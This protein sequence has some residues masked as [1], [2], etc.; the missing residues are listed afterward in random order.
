M[1]GRSVGDESESRLQF[2][3]DKTTRSDK[4]ECDL[5]EQSEA[6]LSTGQRV[7]RRKLIKILTAL[8]KCKKSDEELENYLVALGKD[9][10]EGQP[11]RFDVTESQMTSSQA[12]H[13]G[14]GTSPGSQPVK[15]R[16]RQIPGRS[17]SSGSEENKDEE[18]EEDSPDNPLS[19]RERQGTIPD[20][21]QEV[22]F[23]NSLQNSFVDLNSNVGRRRKDPSQLST[24]S[25]ENLL[26]GKV[27]ETASIKADSAT[28]QDKYLMKHIN[29]VSSHTNLP[30]HVASKSAANLLKPSRT[31]FPTLKPIQDV[32]QIEEKRLL[33]ERTSLKFNKLFDA[34]LKANIR[35]SFNKIKNFSVA[36]SPVVRSLIGRQ[37]SDDS[38]GEMADYNRLLGMPSKALGSSVGGNSWVFK[39]ASGDFE[40]SFSAPKKMEENISISPIRIPSPDG[41]KKKLQLLPV[42]GLIRESTEEDIDH[43][44]SH[45]SRSPASFTLLVFIAHKIIHRHNKEL[46]RKALYCMNG[47]YEPELYSRTSSN[48]SSPRLM[49]APSLLKVPSVSKLSK[50]SVS[51]DMSVSQFA[52]NYQFEKSALLGF[53]RLILSIFERQKIAGFIN[54][55]HNAISVLRNQE[56]L[57][58]MVLIIEKIAFNK[59]RGNFWQ[60]ISSVQGNAYVESK[61]K[62]KARK[63]LISLDKLHLSFPP[64]DIFE[65]I[66]KKAYEDKLNSQRWQR[67]CT[68]AKYI[69]RV[70]STLQ[71]NQMQRA[72][73]AIR[74]ID[75]LKAVLKLGQNQ[76]L[77]KIL[78]QA[79]KDVTKYLA[80]KAK[81]AKIEMMNFKKKG[82]LNNM[83]NNM[84][85]LQLQAIEKLRSITLDKGS[86]K[87]SSNSLKKRLIVVIE[88]HQTTR[89]RT[90]FM[91]LILNNQRFKIDNPTPQISPKNYDVPQIIFTPRTASREQVMKNI[92]LLRIFNSLKEKKIRCFQRIRDMSRIGQ[93][94]SVTNLLKA[95]VTLRLLINVKYGLIATAFHSIYHT[96]NKKHEENEEIMKLRTTACN[97]FIFNLKKKQI[98]ALSKLCIFNTSRK[99]EE[100]NNKMENEKKKSIIVKLVG[101]LESKMHHCFTGLVI[102][103]T[104]VECLDL[105]EKKKESKKAGRR[106][107]WSSAR[108]GDM[109]DMETGELVDPLTGVRLNLRTGERY[110]PRTGKRTLLQKEDMFDAARGEIVDVETGIRYN[111]QTGERHDLETGKKTVWRVGSVLDMKTGE[112]LARREQRE[113]KGGQQSQQPQHQQQS[114]SGSVGG[115]VVGEREES[116]SQQYHTERVD[117]EPDRVS[118]SS[119]ELHKSS[120]SH[121]LSANEPDTSPKKSF[122]TRQGDMIDMETGEL[123]DPLTGVRLNLRTG[124]R[125]DPR[126]GK[127]TLLQKE[128]MFDAA[129]GEIVDVETGI[130][131]NPQTGERHDLETGKKT[132]WRV[133]SVLDMKTGELLAR[134]EQREQKGGQQ[135]QQPQQHGVDSEH[136]I[137]DRAR[138]GSFDLQSSNKKPTTNQPH[139]E[140]NLSQSIII[141][142]SSHHLL[143]ELPPSIALGSLKLFSSRDK[144]TSE[145]RQK[146]GKSASKLESN[147]NSI[148]NVESK[149]ENTQAKPEKQNLLSLIESV[150]SEEYSNLKSNNNLPQVVDKPSPTLPIDDSKDQNIQKTSRGGIEDISLVDSI[151]DEIIQ[152][153]TGLN[154]NVEDFIAQK[155][156]LQKIEQKNQPEESCETPKFNQGE[157]PIPTPLKQVP[158]EIPTK[159]SVPIALNPDVKLDSVNEQYDNINILDEV[160]KSIKLK[161]QTADENK[162]LQNRKGNSINEVSKVID[163]EKKNMHPDAKGQNKD[164]SVSYEQSEVER[165]S[166]AKEELKLKKDGD[167]KL[168]EIVGTTEVDSTN[169]LEYYKEERLFK[170]KNSY[171]TEIGAKKD[172]DVIRIGEIHKSQLDEASTN[173]E[174]KKIGE[175]DDLNKVLRK[176][177]ESIESPLVNEIIGVMAG[178][179]KDLGK[180]KLG[181][182]EK[183]E[184]KY[185]ETGLQGKFQG[186][187][188][189][190]EKTLSVDKEERDKMGEMV[191]NMK[192]KRNDEKKIDKGKRS[193]EE[194]HKQK[195]TVETLTTEKSEI[196]K[197][198]QEKQKETASALE[199]SEAAKADLLKTVE[200]LTTEKSEIENAKADLL[201]TVETLTTE[202][203]EIAKQLQEKQKETASALEQSEAAKADLLKTVET[204][205]TEKSEIENAKADLLKTVE[206]LTTEKS[207]IENAKADLLKTVETLTT[208][209][210]EIENAKADLLKTVE[211]LTTEKSEIENAKAD[212]LK[213]VETLTTEK[214]EIENAKADLLKTVETLTTEKSEIENAKADLLK[215][216]ETLTTE[217]SE[218]ENAKADLLK[219]VET[220]TTE[221]SEIAKQLQEKQKETASALEQSEAA[222]AD[223]LKTVETLTTEKS[224][225]ENAKADLLKTVETLTTEKSEIENAKA[226]LLKT[227][228]T[229]TTEK[230][231]I[232]N[233]KADLLKTVET[234]TTEKSEIE[235]AKADLLKT[236]ET[237]TTEKSEIAKQLQEKQKE[238]ES[239]LEQSEAAKADLLKTVETLTTEK[240]EIE[241]AKADL[242]KTVETLT[243]EKS[244]IENAKA[245]LLKTVE[246]LT[247]E[248]SEIAKQLQEKQKETASALEQSEA[249]KADLLKTVETLTTEKS[250]IAKQLQEKQKET[251]SALEQSEAAKADLLKTVETLTTE[252]SEIENAKADLLKTV[253]T[254]TTEKSEIENAKA[255]L[256]K[257]VETL[258]TEKSEIENAKADLLKTVETLTTEKSEIAKQLQ[259]K[260]KETASALEQSEA[261]KADLLKTVETLTTEKSEIENAKADLLKTVE[262]L[263]TEKSEIENAK[264]DLLKTVETLTTE[265]SEIENAKADLLKT[266]ETLT[267]E[268][269]E[270][271]NAKADLL[272][273]VETLTT[274]KSEIE[275]AKADLLKT[276]ETLT[277]EKSEIENAKAD[278]LK[279][280]ET[281]TTEKS[282]IENA[283]ADLLK[284]V[285]TLTT[286]KSEIEN[287]KADLLK[288]V[289]TLT[290]EK[291][292]IEN[293]K[294]D[295]LKTVETLTT[296]K[297]EIAKQLQEKQKE[298]ASALEQSEAAKADLL[299][300]VETLTTEKSEIE[301][302]KADLLK[303]VE[304]LTT[305]KSEIEN[306]K[307]DLLKTV[308]TLTTEKSEIENAKADLLKTVETLTTEKSE[309][310]KQLQEKQKETASALEQSEAA[311][312]DLLK[313]VETL[314]TEKSEIENAKADLLKTVETLTTEKSEIAKQLQEKQKETESALEQSEAAKADL[315]KTVET[316][317][318]EKS[319]IE[320]AKADL[321]KTVETLTTEKSEI[322]N[323]KADLLKTVETLTTEKSEIENAKADLLKTVETLTTEKSEIAKQLQEKQ[324][325]T[326]SALEQSEAAKADLLK[327]VETLTT[328][329]SE[330]AK[331]LQEKQKETESALEQSEAAKA[332]LLKTVE[333]LTTEKSEIENAKADLLKTV[334]TLTTEKSEIENAKADLLKTVETLTTEKSEIAECEG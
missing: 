192:L 10:K 324:K 262:T 203:S 105:V 304:T 236:V 131:Y 164:R 221:K 255:D 160:N 123:V 224:E 112:L 54:L 6:L 317:T 290:T 90:S 240:S 39:D 99:L 122:T 283:K 217:K 7:L 66:K 129:R 267:T 212:L 40:E 326:A 42:M 188:T 327:T 64:E 109:I 311:K 322:E 137:R 264:A 314:T 252:K 216:V 86:P 55:K 223:L 69:I 174:P 9:K 144:Q 244:E 16:R 93:I 199:Q 249:A 306:A 190:I 21:D 230:S 143:P 176:H 220:L 140:G 247:T 331:Q 28:Y 151:T 146:E 36:S 89:L 2:R 269:S 273:T 141:S 61:K 248:K 52:N 27:V 104:I 12:W 139:S 294:A 299:K 226:D 232:E 13:G 132:V 318:T 77:K 213:T 259:E 207:E 168:K 147:S 152:K 301:N 225:I 175:I 234:L 246:T 44:L 1:E 277:T 23:V 163:L 81:K 272:K 68:E 17:P 177:T 292:E 166:E 110:D 178:R 325:E 274:E 3:M 95:R 114:G 169:I 302:A 157:K 295:L 20:E 270:I 263:T 78:E 76:Y 8:I 242:L 155:T 218:I 165:S 182:E 59:K 142:D 100:L 70:V 167:G 210:S 34:I 67:R 333:T 65:K 296:E 238:T 278:L 323:A 233:A 22:G 63:L 138:Q 159:K 289:E 282:E 94:S 241:N 50:S 120:R 14:R 153:K 231:E 88:L 15:A 189:V 156:T 285:E 202:K 315:L 83:I 31:S 47:I 320:N 265:K 214:S 303:T 243:T 276:V 106:K 92:F 206:T 297:S 198:L 334:E 275:N 41:S 268:K 85:R 84:H 172:D 18:E 102:N 43:R 271:E 312:A 205:T 281:L 101:K 98:N 4:D 113:Q 195:R 116:R 79:Q 321:L 307:A 72:F 316:L 258:T 208:E 293:A 128:D 228:E 186:D 184:E 45:S 37:L 154:T 237:L 82:L 148:S 187:K 201:K 222:K 24:I 256:L 25:R 121:R 130:R 300:T 108:Q 161:G 279:T 185:L 26:P 33:S 115:R 196:A 125:Y 124:E 126:T 150:A 229:L 56:N 239:A 170:D 328:E 298:T 179:N 313:T 197:Q 305:E 257:T 180:V 173:V 329:K 119:L 73:T 91:K 75:E 51:M 5:L 97:K 332:D 308:E 35:I 145:N 87:Q 46:A 11:S 32:N 245:D 107:S 204:L 280:V 254:L 60:I 310:A 136:Y 288:T 117:S 118:Q 219:T 48:K 96:S 127:R 250:E 200:T 71:Q 286:E 103:G 309:I 194:K 62:E 251:A 38:L 57:K 111:P 30:S 74:A 284:T 227:V 191:G 266:V 330:I 193:E 19:Q 29:T 133:G 260:Q 135:S 253:E 291:S 162:D 235:N 183:A 215:T 53:N 287:A 149:N 181:M 209:K 49:L 319:E 171:D 134:R 211:T 58:R 158:A 80:T 261:A